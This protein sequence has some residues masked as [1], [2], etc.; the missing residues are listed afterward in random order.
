[1]FGSTYF[2]V[3][4]YACQNGNLN[5]INDF[6]TDSYKIYPNP[7]SSNIYIN[8]DN[9]I[10]ST[11]IRILDI[12]GRLIKQETIKTKKTEL[13]ISNL[14][15]GLYIIEIINNSRCFKYKFLKE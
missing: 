3:L 4:E 2:K 1:P 5:D 10:K 14:Q 9:D 7:S 15:N 8:T 6:I 11:F 12:T 13:D